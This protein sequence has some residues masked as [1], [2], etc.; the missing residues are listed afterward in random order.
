M[1]IILISEIPEEINSSNILNQNN[2]LINNLKSEDN[3]DEV[4]AQETE[5]IAI[6]PNKIKSVIAQQECEDTIDQIDNSKSNNEEKK[7]LMVEIDR[8]NYTQNDN[9]EDYRFNVQE[10]LYDIKNPKLNMTL[11]LPPPPEDFPDYS[12]SATSVS[13]SPLSPCLPLPPPPIPP[14]PAEECLVETSCTPIPPPIPA[15]PQE[16][17]LEVPTEIVPELPPPPTEEELSITDDPPASEIPPRPPLPLVDDL[18]IDN[19][20]HSVNIPP[21]PPPPPMAMAPPPPPPPPPPSSKIDYNALGARPKNPMHV[22]AVD[23]HADLMTELLSFTKGGKKKNKKEDTI[24]IVVNLP[25]KPKVA[26]KSD[27]KQD[28]P[29]ENIQGSVTIKPAPP[30]LIP[31]LNDMEMVSYPKARTDSAINVAN[32]EIEKRC[33]ERKLSRKENDSDEDIYEAYRYDQLSTTPFN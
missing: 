11:S 31:T 15:P 26:S 27:P 12:C 8:E 29:I 1:I 14:P 9:T 30:K 18:L 10:N 17:N 33:N 13:P 23:M 22:G 5:E 24:D 3:E 7:K 20:I 16:E 2:D 32:I 21:P 4:I 28:K 19:Y 25:I 6:N